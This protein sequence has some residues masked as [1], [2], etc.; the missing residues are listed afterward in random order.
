MTASSQ[1]LIGALA[2]LMSAPFLVPLDAPGLAY[3]VV[4]A[5]AVWATTWLRARWKFGRGITVSPASLRVDE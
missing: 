5:V 3:V 2:V 4:A 1:L